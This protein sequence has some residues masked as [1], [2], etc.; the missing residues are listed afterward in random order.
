MRTLIRTNVDLANLLALAIAGGLLAGAL[1]FQYIGGLHPCEMCM[2]QRWPHCA[3]LVL[4][5]LA[6]FAKGRARIALI[7]LAAA[8]ISAS[9]I[10]GFYHAG[11]ELKIFTGHTACT[12]MASAKPGEDFLDVIMHMPITRCDEP[13]WSLF[14]VSMAGWNGIVSTLGALAVIIVLRRGKWRREH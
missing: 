14:G 6:V 5:T 11:V 13:A 4:A 1:G 2:W 12:M 7:T 9:G 8:A 10:T 3:A